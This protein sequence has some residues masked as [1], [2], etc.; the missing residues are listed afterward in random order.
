MSVHAAGKLVGGRERSRA[1]CWVTVV[2]KYEVA[3]RFEVALASTM[4][5]PRTHVR[6]C[7]DSEAGRSAVRS[8]SFGRD[9]L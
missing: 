3:A 2:S 6:R 9:S 1:G 4:T 5:D 8:T 7:R